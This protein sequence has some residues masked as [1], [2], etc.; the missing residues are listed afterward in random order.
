MQ[1]NLLRDVQW[2]DSKVVF[3]M[4]TLMHCVLKPW[5]ESNV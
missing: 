5:F 1:V 3:E 2:P 4:H